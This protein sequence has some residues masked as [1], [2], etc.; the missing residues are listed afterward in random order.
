[1]S[2]SALTSDDPPGPPTDGPAGDLRAGRNLLFLT[3]AAV[4]ARSRGSKHLV[5][6]VCETDYSGYPDCRDDTIKALQVAI[7]LGM[8][9]RLRDRDAAHVDDKAATWELAAS[10]GRRGISCASSA[11]RRIAATRAARGISH[12]WGVG[13]GTCDACRLRASGWERWDEVRR[14]PA[15]LDSNLRSIPILRIARSYFT[16][17]AEPKIRFRSAGQFSQPFAWI[18]LSSCP[19]DQP[20]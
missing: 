6:G 13:C 18:S 7:N 4:V 16:S 15:S 8:E 3:F 20:A 10:L 11:T 5:T 14:A 12:P 17:S 1:M 19:G 9:A 2:V